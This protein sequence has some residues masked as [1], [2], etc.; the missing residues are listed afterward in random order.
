MQGVGRSANVA[1]NRARRMWQSARAGRRWGRRLGCRRNLSSCTD[2]NVTTGWA[3]E[4]ASKRRAESMSQS[5]VP[6]VAGSDVL[7]SVAGSGRLAHARW[8]CCTSGE[9]MRWG[10]AA[11]TPL[12]CAERPAHARMPVCLA[13]TRALCT[14]K[15]RTC[16]PC[17]SI[18][19]GQ[20]AWTCPSQ[21]G[22][23]T[24]P[25]ASSFRETDRALL[26]KSQ[27]ERVSRVAVSLPA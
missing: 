8:N 12:V 24:R 25:W 22:F 16:E 4:R 13:R 9:C 27:V 7:V 18:A 23:V 15:T 11:A 19:C 20:V 10:H 2:V 21:R 3:G 6:Q 5:F 1:I 26:S 17:G 14:C